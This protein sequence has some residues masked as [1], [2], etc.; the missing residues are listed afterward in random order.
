MDY[1]NERKL[2][3]N[4]N[5]MEVYRKYSKEISISKFNTY[6]DVEGINSS[7]QA[8]NMPKW[9]WVIKKYIIEVGVFLR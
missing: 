3:R 6:P 2:Y 8:Y 1:C 7:G 5:F 4:I 9:K